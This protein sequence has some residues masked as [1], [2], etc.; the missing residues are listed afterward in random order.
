MAAGT[1]GGPGFSATG[2]RIAVTRSGS[3]VFLAHA[4]GEFTTAEIDDGA[5]PV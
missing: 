1:R 4:G 2:G 3:A 5:R